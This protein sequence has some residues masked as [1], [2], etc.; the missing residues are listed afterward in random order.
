LVVV[1][2]VAS[3]A[4][5]L[6]PPLLLRG[7]HAATKHEAPDKEKAYVPFGDEKSKDIVAN[8]LSPNQN[9]YLKLRITLVTDKAEEKHLTELLKKQSSVLRNALF[10]YLAGRT[11]EDIRGTAG[12][13]RVRR[14][15][16][17]EFNR[18]LYPEGSE[19]VRDLLFDDFTTQV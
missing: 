1:G 6:A 12:V 14:E 16:L 10:T 13:N 11:V 2:V 4:G 17:D 9:R 18:L 5:G 19:K 8:L 15:L 3:L 7:S